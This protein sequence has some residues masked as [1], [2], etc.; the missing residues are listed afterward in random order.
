MIKINTKKRKTPPPTTLTQKQIDQLAQE[1]VLT[2]LCPICD[3]LKDWFKA[4]SS[5]AKPQ[6]P[7]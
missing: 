4:K 3:N 7:R 1:N 6:K 2:R 5:D